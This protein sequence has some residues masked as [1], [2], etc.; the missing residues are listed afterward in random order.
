[1]LKIDDSEKIDEN[2]AFYRIG[3]GCNDGQLR[4]YKIKKT[5]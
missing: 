4:I 1:M 3:L 2:D 5:L